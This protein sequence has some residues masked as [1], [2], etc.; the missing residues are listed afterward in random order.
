MA[1]AYSSKN[2]GRWGRRITQVQ[3]KTVSN[4]SKHHHHHHNNNNNNNTHTFEN[5]LGLKMTNGLNCIPLCSVLLPR[6]LI[7][8]P[9]SWLYVIPL[10]AHLHRM[11]VWTASPML[12]SCCY[13]DVLLLT[14]LCLQDLIREPSASS[15]ALFP[16]WITLGFLWGDCQSQIEMSGKNLFHHG[17]TN[18]F[19][20]L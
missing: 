2:L 1:C 17:V 11:R 14:Q 13:M 19:R 8:L 7:C 10:N 18:L 9:T 20:E 12:Q 5:V 3:N 6:L 4:H 15:L 16:S